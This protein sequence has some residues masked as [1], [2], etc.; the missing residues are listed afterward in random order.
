MTT[1]QKEPIVRLR[2]LQ[3]ANTIIVSAKEV[4]VF[5]SNDSWHEN[6]NAAFQKKKEGSILC[7]R[8]AKYVFRASTYFCMASRP[9][10]VILQI[11]RGLVPELS[12]SFVM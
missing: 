8:P 6:M 9:I 11:V 1:N 5:Q 2:T 4:K 10:S 3:Q 12:V 7:Y